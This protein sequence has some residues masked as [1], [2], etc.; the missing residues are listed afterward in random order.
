MK[1]GL[2]ISKQIEKNKLNTERVNEERY[3]GEVEY[4]HVEEFWRKNG[5]DEK[6]VVHGETD[7]G[8]QC[9]GRR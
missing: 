1:D 7:G 2:K 8:S 9:R 6:V 3:K 4:C 5:P